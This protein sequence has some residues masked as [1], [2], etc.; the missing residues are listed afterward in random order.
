MNRR[1]G[2]T[3][4]EILAGVLIVLAIII[5]TL[6]LVG[7]TSFMVEQ[8]TKEICVRRIHGA[9]F[10]N[11]NSILSKEFLRLISVAILL[12]WPLAYYSITNWLNNFSQ[13]IEMQ[14]FVFLVSGVLAFLLVMVI[15]S[16]HAKR[17]TAIN[18]AHIL[19]YE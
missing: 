9:T 18:P 12:S 15:T 7:L 1:T 10:K 3:N 14:W 11:I 13:H 16:I 17:A 2:I 19:K 6:G 5:A 4:I 8:K